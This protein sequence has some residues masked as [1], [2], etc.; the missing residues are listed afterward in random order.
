MCAEQGKR[1]R[2]SDTN[3][4]NHEKSFKRRELDI[5]QIMKQCGMNSNEWEGYRLHEGKQIKE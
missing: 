2:P 3:C 1:E 4:I 5:R